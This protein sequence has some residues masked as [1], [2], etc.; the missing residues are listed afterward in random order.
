MYEINIFFVFYEYKLYKIQ[1]SE[2]GIMQCI[3]DTVKLRGGQS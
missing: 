2:S 3:C 1:I